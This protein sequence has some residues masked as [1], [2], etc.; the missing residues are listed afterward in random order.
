LAQHGEVNNHE[1][2]MLDKELKQRS[3]ADELKKQ[4]E[5]RD[6]L[7]KKEEWRKTRAAQFAI[8][9]NEN[10]NQA[11]PQNLMHTAYN[12]PGEAL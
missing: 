4:I 10:Q 8:E 2:K 6:F 7:R 5:E 3:F 11:N 1:T 12:N 9:R